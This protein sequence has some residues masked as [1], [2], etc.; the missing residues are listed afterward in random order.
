[1]E[2]MKFPVNF[3]DKY[4]TGVWAGD[5]GLSSVPLLPVNVGINELTQSRSLIGH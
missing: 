2:D 4:G 3:S 5:A 1:M